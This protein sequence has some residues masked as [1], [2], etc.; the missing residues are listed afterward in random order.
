[1]GKVLKIEW[2]LFRILLGFD[3]FFFLE[4]FWRDI[5]VGL[6]W[7]GDYDLLFI[8][9]R[10]ADC[11]VCGEEGVGGVR[12]GD[13]GKDCCCWWSFGMVVVGNDRVF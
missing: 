5:G 4:D 3:G 8:G 10:V 9:D 12:C 7:V 11:G 6:S 2:I 1:M 13:D